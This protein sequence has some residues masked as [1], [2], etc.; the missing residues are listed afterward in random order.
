MVSSEP[1]IQILSHLL[2]LLAIPDHLTFEEHS[3]YFG[4]ERQMPLSL[5]IER[6][7]ESEQFPASYHSGEG[8]VNW[9]NRSI[10]ERQRSLLPLRAKGKTSTAR[11][12][13][14][15]K[16]TY[17]NVQSISIASWLWAC[18]R[19]LLCILNALS[20][21]LMFTATLPIA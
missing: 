12:L 19:W 13:E 4:Q 8:N 17:G 1:K 7:L 21:Y 11:F 15:L 2:H 9:S 20:T 14:S 5:L 6:L 10:I 16:S 18:G 3:F